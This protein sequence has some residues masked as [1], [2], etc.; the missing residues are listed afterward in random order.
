MLGTIHHNHLVKLFV[1]YVINLDNL[2]SKFDAIEILF[3]DSLKKH[4]FHLFS[5]TLVV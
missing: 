5:C 3:I 4:M 1:R 2:N